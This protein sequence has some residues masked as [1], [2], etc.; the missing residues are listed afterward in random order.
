LDFL[1][2]LQKKPVIAA[3]RDIESFRIQDLKHT[4]ILFFL[5]GTIFDLPRVVDQ[6]RRYKKLVFVDI[7]LIKGIGR[8]APGIRFLVK[9][10]EVD[11]IITTH[12]NL[13]KS[14]QQEG[15]ASIQRIFVL[16]SESLKGGL[17]AIERSNPDALEILPGL[18]LPKI[19]KKIG[20]ITSLPVIA[21]G[22]ITREEEID[23]IL[24]SGA[25]GVST[26][27]PHLFD[28]QGKR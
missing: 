5:G 14:A 26:T 8:D 1:T 17:R 4:N 7:D 6:A 3:F 19:I 13:I 16:D 10:S 21:G 24:A 11:G 18:V 22:L 9:E 15:L 28:Y 25:V 20:M 27:S 2:I 23:E 12:S